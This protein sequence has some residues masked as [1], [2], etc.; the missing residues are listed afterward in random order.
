[1]RQKAVAR[2]AERDSQLPPGAATS[3]APMDDGLI[4]S[5]V[6]SAHSSFYCTRTLQ[7]LNLEK[8]TEKATK[9]ACFLRE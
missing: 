3:L 8:A 7:A 6:R 9:K 4:R 1:M 5:P 2:V